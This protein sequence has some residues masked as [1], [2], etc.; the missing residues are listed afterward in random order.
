MAK[1]RRPAVRS[2]FQFIGASEEVYPPCMVGVNGV[3]ALDLNETVISGAMRIFTLRFADQISAACYRMNYAIAA[4][5]R[6]H[7]H[8]CGFTELPA[9]G[10]LLPA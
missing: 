6:Y 8:S 2:E 7:L 9:F 3:S 5:N 4:P 1:V 10:K